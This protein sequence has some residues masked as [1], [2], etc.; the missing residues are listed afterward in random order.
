MRIYIY[1]YIY[2]NAHG[3]TLTNCSTYYKTYTPK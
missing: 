3:K 2:G 1:I